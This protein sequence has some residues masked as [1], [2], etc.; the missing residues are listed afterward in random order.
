MTG[1]VIPLHGDPH[2]DILALLPWYAKGLLDDKDRAAVD[3]HL[4]ACPACQAELAQETKLHAVLTMASIPSNISAD[5]DQGWAAMQRLAGVRPERRRANAPIWSSTWSTIREQWQTGAPWLRW[6][7]ATQF[8]CLLLFGGL[9]FGDLAFRPHPAPAQYQGQY[10][11][12]Y[13][14]L[15]AAAAPSASVQATANIIIMFQPNT[16]EQDMRRILKAS[17]ARMIDGPTSADAYMLRVPAARRTAIV[18]TLKHEQAVTLAQ[19]VDA[20][21]VP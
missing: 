15:S 10:Q 8:A 5:V 20:G 13:R 18:A 14:T 16:S 17:D 11:A 9:F 2:R 12:R 1:D 19:P 6:T 21:W 4:R 3:M 7:V